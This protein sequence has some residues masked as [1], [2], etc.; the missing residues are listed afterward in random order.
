MKIKYFHKGIDT[1]SLPEMFRSIL[2]TDKVPVYFKNREPPIISHPNTVASKLFN[3]VVNSFKSGCQKLSVKSKELPVSD[4][5]IL[6][7]TSWTYHNWRFE[8]YRECQAERS[9]FQR[10][11]IQRA[12]QDKLKSDRKHDL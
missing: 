10:T 11:Q 12:K 5:Q 9:Y 2:V 4:V 1:I 3:F 7:T 8:D 6:L